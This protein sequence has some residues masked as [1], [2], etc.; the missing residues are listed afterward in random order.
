MKVIIAGS[1]GIRD[2]TVVEKAIASSGFTITELVSGTA[3]GVDRLGEQWA[4]KYNI[5]I[6]KFPAAWREYGPKAGALRNR[7]M[8][9]YADALVAVW[10]GASPGTKNMILFMRDR[11]RKPTAITVVVSLSEVEDEL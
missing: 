11:L 6:K 4:E 1:R 3:R 7:E 5:P 10:D 8:G 2:Y 9:R